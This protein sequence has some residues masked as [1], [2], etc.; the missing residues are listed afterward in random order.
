MMKL[1]RMIHNIMQHPTATATSKRKHL[2]QLMGQLG[3][4]SE[5]AEELEEAYITITECIEIVTDQ[6]EMEIFQKKHLGTNMYGIM[7]YSRNA[8]RSE[9][10]KQLDNEINSLNQAHEFK[11]RKYDKGAN[12]SLTQ[13]FLNKQP[14]TVTE[15]DRTLEFFLTYNILS[16]QQVQ[17]IRAKAAYL[18]KDCNKMTL[19]ERIDF[20]LNKNFP[21]SVKRKHLLYLLNHLE[22]YSDDE[23]TIA[24]AFARITNELNYVY[25]EASTYEPPTVPELDH[26]LEFF[27]TCNIL[28]MQQ[29]QEIRAKAAAYLR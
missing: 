22:V 14:L 4:Y 10:L 8:G 11:A 2:Q 24:E 19:Q 3:E 21:A 9:C 25:D 5:N 6:E 17:E 18:R 13:E 7:R 20:I 27:L 23:K 12:G 26:T 15:L 1:Q 28:S 16:I 29:V